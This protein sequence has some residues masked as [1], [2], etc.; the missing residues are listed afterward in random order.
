M[1]HVRYVTAGEEEIRYKLREAGDASSTDVLVLIHGLAWTGEVWT[2]IEKRLR[3]VRII[4]PDMPGNGV[5]EPSSSYSFDLLSD[6][7]SDLLDQLHVRRV[8]LVGHSWGANLAMYFATHD[9]KRV[10]SLMLVDAGYLNY[11]EWPG[12]T[13]EDFSNFSFPEALLRNMERFINDQK[14]DTPYWNAD[15]ENAVRDIVH[16][17]KDGRVAFNCPVETKQACAQALWTFHPHDVVAQLTIPVTLVIAKSAAES[18]EQVD[19][20]KKHAM[21]QFL[22]HAKQG[23]CVMMKNTSHM[24]M[25]ERP[26]ELAEEIK[27][28]FAG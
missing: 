12:M 18:D 25:L 6:Q 14:Q 10:R 15:V 19:A 21:D 28:M 11:Q 4:A 24:V 17:T 27:T 3:G 22:A 23:R 9:S 16:E 1:W 2:L 8:W 5:S 20:Y 7:L 13:W 26:N